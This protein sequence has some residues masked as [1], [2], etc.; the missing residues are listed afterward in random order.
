MLRQY[1]TDQLAEYGNASLYKSLPD[2]ETKLK[3]RLLN[4]DDQFIDR[5]TVEAQNRFFN[6][7]DSLYKAQDIPGR[8]RSK[9]REKIENPDVSGY[10]A[11]FSASMMGIGGGAMSYG[12]WIPRS[13]GGYSIGDRPVFVK[14]EGDNI[15]YWS[16][17]VIFTQEFVD[18]SQTGGSGSA[19][20]LN[21]SVEFEVNWKSTLQEDG[22]LINA[23]VTEIKDVYTS[24]YP[25]FGGWF[26]SSLTQNVQP[27]DPLSANW[28]DRP[29]VSGASTLGQGTVPVTSYSRSVS[30]SQSPSSS[31]SSSPSPSPSPEP[32]EDRESE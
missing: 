12:T 23:E 28:Y 27:L 13:S 5:V 8:I 20:L 31:P 6:D 15:L 30:S 22:N 9:F 3:L 26:E 16:S 11:P 2:Y 10:I 18:A 29:L 14:K 32:Q 21:Y 17:T 19:R 1:L 7:E 25:S 4:E 24:A